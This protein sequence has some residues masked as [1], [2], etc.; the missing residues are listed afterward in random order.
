MI[1]YIYTHR[2]HS[3][4]SL[5]FI[6]Q[7]SKRYASIMLTDIDGCSLCFLLRLW[8]HIPVFQSTFLIQGCAPPVI[9]WLK[10]TISYL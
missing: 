6:S 9:S 1:T 10:R 7:L 3:F 5:E 4:H 2:L 8:K